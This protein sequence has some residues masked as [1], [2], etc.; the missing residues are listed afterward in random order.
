MTTI[1]SSLLGLISV[2][3]PLYG[4]V[5]EYDFV[6]EF[7]VILL[8][9]LMGILLILGSYLI[10]RETAIRKKEWIRYIL[11]AIL[12]F[13]V[14][15]IFPYKLIV[16]SNLQFSQNINFFIFLISFAI[17]VTVLYYIEN[18]T[19]N[20]TLA[21]TEYKKLLNNS[22]NESMFINNKDRVIK[23]M[24]NSKI[25][26]KPLMKK[27]LKNKEKFEWFLR[28]SIVV[29]VFSLV[30]WINFFYLQFDELKNNSTEFEG[31]NIVSTFNRLNNR[32]D[33]TDIS[34]IRA[35]KSIEG[36]KTYVD[37]PIKN[38]INIKGLIHIIEVRKNEL[39]ERRQILNEDRSKFIQLTIISYINHV[40]QVIFVIVIFFRITGFQKN[41]V[42]KYNYNNYYEIYFLVKE[43]NHYDEVSNL[44][45]SNNTKKIYKN[46]IISCE[47]YLIDAINRP[48]NLKKTKNTVL[49]I[50]VL[51]II[52]MTIIRF[53]F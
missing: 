18:N 51:S 14:F 40:M 52:I 12:V 36:L 13:L 23:T 41:V 44:L 19:F 1:I 26:L 45:G 32:I 31:Y 53:A 17:S 46:A 39:A 42:K 27:S 33:R 11:I 3:I 16:D 48:M 34:I 4:L 50:I 29:V 30:L 49:Q 35:N 8:F 38:Q 7:S 21:Y 9:I 24:I 47:E 43:H 2:I 28:F 20:Y 15:I 6:S 5:I 10:L 37:K 22:K 25:N